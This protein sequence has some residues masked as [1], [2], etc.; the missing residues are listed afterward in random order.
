MHWPWQKSSRPD[1]AEVWGENAD[2]T[3]YV[4]GMTVGELREALSEFKEGD[5][6]CMAVCPKKYWNGG[7]YFGKLKAIN[8]GTTGQIWLK[9]RVLDASLETPE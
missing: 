1:K 3:P 6:V 8:A 5:E 7:G 9:G 4:V 2:G